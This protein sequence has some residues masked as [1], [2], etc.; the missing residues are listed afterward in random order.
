MKSQAREQRLEIISPRN[1]DCDVANRVLEDEIPTDDPR[2]ELAECRV[3]V[4]VR[5][6][7][8]WNHRCELRI[9]KCSERANK[10]EQEERKNER[11]SR[12]TPDNMTGRVGLSRRGR[13]NRPKD[14]GANDSADREHYQ[15]AGS[16]RPP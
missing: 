4:S 6:P 11:G 3:R 7:R 14:S 8:L 2:D 12:S 9:T 13:S 5:A 1:G 16:Q 10:A 15:V